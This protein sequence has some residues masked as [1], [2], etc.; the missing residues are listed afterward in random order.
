MKRTIFVFGEPVPLIS[1]PLAS[2]CER[3][4]NLIKSPTTVLS[5]SLRMTAAPIHNFINL[6]TFA[7][8]IAISLA[9][10]TA[11]RPLFAQGTPYEGPVG[12]SGIFNGNST[13]GGSYDPLS[14]SAHRAID[15]IVVPGSIGKYPLKMTRY[16]NSRAQYYA[17]TAIGLGPG[18]SHEYSWL[19]WGGDT[20]V[21]SPHGGVYDFSCGP[22]VGVSEGWEGGSPANGTGTWRLAD[23][24]KVVFNGDGQHSGK[25]TDI[26]DPYGQRTTIT[27]DDNTGQRI[28]VTEPGGRYL[29]FIYGPDTDPR[30]GTKMLKTVE[31]HGLGNATVTDSVTYTYTAVSPGVTGREKLMLTKAT[32]SDGTSATYTYTNDNVSPANSKWYP[33]L[34]R[35]DDY[36]YNGP[37]RTIFY[38]YQSGGPHGAIIDEKYPGVGN[39][40]A[41]TPNLP[42]GNGGSPDNF[43]E[44]RGDGPIRTFTYTHLVPCVP[45]DCGGPCA[46]YGESEPHNKMLTDYT[47]FDEHNTHMEYDPN[48]WYVTSVLDT[49]GNTT[50]YARAS[51]PPTGI[52]QITKITH[53]DQ[54][55]IDYGYQSEG[56]NIGGHYLA[57][58]TEYTPANLL[59]SQ[60]IHYRDATTHKITQTNYNDGNGALLAS[61]T[62]SYCD[63]SDANQCGPVNPTTG[64]MHGQI[65]THKLK[66]G[67]YVHYRYDAG[68]RGLLVDK[69]EPTWNGT[70]LDT[71]P[72]THYT[73]YPDGEAG[74][75]RWTDRLKTRTLPANTSGNIASE[76]YE[77]DVVSGTSPNGNPVAGR[78]LV[79][80]ITHAD[81]KYRSFGYDAYGN[82]LWEENEL[83]NHTSYTYDSYNRVLTIKDPIG[84]TTNRTTTY[85]YAP[86][87]G[88]G[89]SSYLHTT[90]SPDTVTTPAGIKTTNVYDK[91]FRKTQSSV[92]GK[93][94]WFHYDAFGNQDYV[95]DP[96]GTSSPGNYTTYTDYDSRNRK[97]QV[98]EPLGHTTQFYYDDGINITRI[99]RP[100]ETT[101]TKVYDGMNRLKT[102]TVPKDTGV[103]IVTQFVYNPWNGDPADGL[104]SGSLLQKVIDGESHNCQFKYDPAGLKTQM[105]Y[106]DGSSQQWAYDDAHN[107]ESRTT[108]NNETQNFEYDVRNRKTKEWWNGWPPDGEW[109]AFGYDDA[110]RLTL[111]TN[112]LSAYWTNFIADVRRFYDDAGRL[113]LD[114][115]TVYVTGIGN[116]KDVNYPTYDDD[117]RLTRMYVYGVSP[118][119]DYTFTYDAMGRFETIKPT[120][121]SLLFQYYYDPASNET[122]RYN[123]SNRIAQIYDPD[124]LNRMKSVEVKNTLTNTRLGIENY[125]Y[126]TISRLR[127]VTRE[128]NLQDSFTYYLD[129]ELKVA[130]YGAAPTPPPTPTPP[131]GQA[132]EPGFNPDGGSSNQHTLNVVIST[133][134]AGAQMRYTINDPQPPS[135]SYGTLINGT[136]GTVTLSLGH[137]TMQAIAFKAGMTDSPIHS[138]D[139]DYEGGGQRPMTYPLDMAGIQSSQG[140]AAPNVSTVSYTLDEAGNRLTVNGT[141]YS[142][143]SINQYTSVGGSAVTNGLDHEIKVYGGFTY[144]YM[145]DQELTKVTAT[146]FTY[147]LAF[148]ALGRCV[149]RIINN[150][151]AYTTY[152]I[153]DGDKP[154]LEY[155]LNGQIARNLYGKGID[156][157]VMRT[158]PA[159]NGNQA[160]YFQQD[161]EGS[162]THVT[163]LNNGS[164]QII[165]RYRYDVFGLPTIYAPDW[166]VRTGS[167]YGNRF[168][169]TGREYDGA[170]VY[171]YRARLYHSGL[172]RFMSEDPK[173]FDAGDY[174][175]FRYCHNDP[176][177]FTDPMG[178]DA[179][180]N[181]MAVV[182]VVVPGQY[183]YNQMVA[184]FQAGN[185]GTAAG[186]GVTMAASTV[187]G[188]L[189]GTGTTR[190]Q[191]GL[192][193]A[194]TAA[195]Q[196]NVLAV[197]GK[198]KAVP[199]YVQVGEHLNKKVFNIST[200]LWKEMTPA[201]RWAAT[202]KFL[203]SII[204]QKGDFLLHRSIKSIGSQSGEFRKELN[205]ISQKGYVLSQD[206]WSMTRAAEEADTAS[207][208][209]PLTLKP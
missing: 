50:A 137:A 173:L 43:T 143:N 56:S 131:G 28:Q 96:R 47:D 169:F 171:E 154:I 168:L 148:D 41:I 49:R 23:G 161:H 65:K 204:A 74:K 118:A 120:G 165:E 177:D 72:K 191:A 195:A 71:D 79:T 61:E 30:D 33:L 160:F 172:G 52:G 19:V 64:Q 178:L 129:G 92:D 34:Q 62:F 99:I 69:W 139:F 138:A 194:E 85:T 104:H 51:P 116:T 3:G 157:I 181:A 97:W 103:N 115:Q 122:Q 86:T 76:T 25:V 75:N 156:E 26:Y 37:M 87:N 124:E 101:E 77:Y 88:G 126:Y 193:A 98:R 123:W 40:S 203:D 110:S 180:T 24:G 89:G 159:V 205:Y 206:G 42:A 108:V 176:I 209:V 170:W 164:G 113:T 45:D 27:Y 150:D 207:R 32:Y 95:T 67:A 146:G 182:E 196:R 38:D 201:Q 55:H 13:T 7:G 132:A 44:T 208:H 109:R 70:A 151:P 10:A 9:I 17:L 39:V 174:N 162:T 1:Q 6:I 31:A 187:V 142:P 83:R 111:A 2:Y 128:D 21:V 185:Y 140:P 144:T 82:K 198:F 119:Y 133:T 184:N 73:Y 63:Q 16:Y 125:D 22:P 202:Q 4:R 106:H 163:N 127:S 81:G 59:R 149:R 66:N 153:Y 145:R 192:R 57:S 84:Q 12:V 91:N 48:T 166:T 134:T 54:T 158:D 5:R 200:Q 53:A 15:D 130:T 29:K 199:N 112:G 60:T 167:S 78:G 107:L 175:L 190:L 68:G 100:D 135:S 117:G 11:A 197:I 93:T 58:I 8:R 121:G 20:R 152:Y 36:R 141:S 90:N 35:C 179:M 46:A 155:R 188:V 102:D 186:W 147:D 80:K 183:E 114:R 105:T 14:H 136:S 94:T 18:W 189:S